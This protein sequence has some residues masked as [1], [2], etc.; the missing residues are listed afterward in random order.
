MTN[1]WQWAWHWCSHHRISYHSHCVGFETFQMSKLFLDSTVVCIVKVM[2]TYMHLHV[3]LVNLFLRVE[4]M[5][6]Y[7]LPEG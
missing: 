6:A 1:H 2:E 7:R 5:V 4:F 3:S